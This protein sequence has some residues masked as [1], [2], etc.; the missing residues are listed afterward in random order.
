M[1]N[2]VRRASELKV[3]MI[4]ALSFVFVLILSYYTSAKSA[5]PGIDDILKRPGFSVDF[6]GIFVGFF[7]LS[8]STLSIVKAYEIFRGSSKKEDG[9]SHF[10]SSEIDSLKSELDKVCCE[11]KIKNSEIEA[12]SSKLRHTE[13]IV[14]ERVNSE[15]LI[16]KSLGALRKEYEK[17]LNEK[18]SLDLELNRLKLEKLFPKEEAKNV[19]VREEEKK[20]KEEKAIED[21]ISKME[22]EVK[23]KSKKNST[24]GKTKVKKKIKPVKKGKKK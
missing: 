21:F 19:E 16:K 13:E 2:I 4:F 20:Q 11:L 5:A 23:A 10:L 7:A 17:L 9:V 3:R 8:L 1:Y 22:E 6:G 24:I 15:N 14:D 12:L 18:E